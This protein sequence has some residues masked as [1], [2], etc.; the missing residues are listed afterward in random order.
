V[1]MNHIF[2]IHSAE[3]HLACFQFLVI[4]DKPAMS[5]VEQQSLWYGRVFFVYIPLSGTAGF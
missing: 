5:I 2:F 1:Q 3:G 4:M